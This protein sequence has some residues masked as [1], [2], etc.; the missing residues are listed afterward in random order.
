MKISS[1]TVP[2]R[3]P[4]NLF[5][6][7]YVSDPWK[8]LCCVIM[9][10]L[11]SGRQLEGIHDDFFTLWPTPLDLVLEDPL[12][13]EALITPLGLQR[14]RARSLILMSA[15]YAFLWD[16]KDPRSLPGIGQYG[17]DSYNIFVRREPGVI[18]TDKEL[19]KYLEWQRSTRC[20]E[21]P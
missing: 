16:G 4:Y 7:R 17:A 8:L 10:N 12:D 21:S 20:K 3:S 2:E 9:L 13:V 1:H 19:R 6:E 18:P 14:R 11:T 15:A 5:Q